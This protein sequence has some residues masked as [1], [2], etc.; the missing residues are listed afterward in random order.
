MSDGV[1]DTGRWRARHHSSVEFVGWD[2]DAPDAEFEEWFRVDSKQDCD[3]LIALLTEV[4]ER[5]P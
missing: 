2:I 5:L 4:R 1:K 3:D